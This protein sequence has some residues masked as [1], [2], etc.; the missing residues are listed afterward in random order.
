MDTET[1]PAGEQP[2]ATQDQTT[3]GEQ[4]AS[5]SVETAPQ[6]SLEGLTSAQLL[7]ALEETEYREQSTETQEHPE[8]EEPEA[9]VAQEETAPAGET[10]TTTENRPLRRL[11]LGGIEEAQRNE[12]AD[13]AAL[14]REGKAK[15]LAEA[16][17]LLRGDDPQ[18]TT[19][20]ATDRID[21]PPVGQV[22]ASVAAIQDQ[23]ATL[24]EQRDIADDEFD[25]P[26]V[27]KLTNQIE[28]LQIEL[29]RAEMAEEKIS[30]VIR[31]WDN[32]HNEACD[33]V[34]EKFNDF[35][36][37]NPAFYDLLETKRVALEANN[38]PSLRDPRFIVKEAEKIAAIL[39]WNK[40]VTPAPKAKAGTPNGQ[41]LAP[42]HQSAARITRAEAQRAIHEMPIEELK[43]LICTE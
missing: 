26:E 41:D 31:D 9:P 5:R 23:I 1:Q 7:A 19:P 13:A 17:N 15:T 32:Q 4:L 43:A 39:G 8:H 38:D 25:K 33:E 21:T 40:P 14:I 42:A 30:A 28:D 20:A 18:E 34:E 12:F 35:A 6:S 27:R 22:P 11:P 2:A 3:A 37:V 16:V 24:R 36:K 29:V 10:E